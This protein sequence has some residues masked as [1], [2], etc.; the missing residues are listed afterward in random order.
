VEGLEELGQGELMNLLMSKAIVEMQKVKPDFRPE[1][2]R[3]S[4]EE[5]IVSGIVVGAAFRM[6]G[7]ATSHIAGREAKK[8]VD[9]AAALDEEGKR[10]VERFIELQKKKEFPK[11]GEFEEHEDYL[12]R[13]DEL[14]RTELVEVSL[15][16]EKERLKKSHAEKPRVPDVINPLAR[17]EARVETIADPAHKQDLQDKIEGR[18]DDLIPGVVKDIPFN[19]A[20]KTLEEQKIPYTIEAMDAGGVGTLNKHRKTHAAADVDIKAIWGDIIQK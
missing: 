20:V 3:G 16:A 13:L 17:D 2:E 12:R 15:A 14:E 19:E 11:K 5:E 10:E 8:E 4:R 18:K 1:W 6:G 7:H 9:E